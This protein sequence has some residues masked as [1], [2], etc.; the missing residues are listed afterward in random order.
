M[1]RSAVTAFSLVLFGCG[2]H[3]AKYKFDDV[4]LASVPMTEKQS[5][6]A[7]EQ[8]VSVAKAKRQAAEADV[9][10]TEHDIDLARVER[11]QARLSTQTAK[12]EMDAAEKAHDMNRQGPASD[13]KR[14]ADL[15]ERVA[16]AKVDMLDQKRK[17]QN[18]LI[19]VGDAQIDAALSRVEYEK[20][21]LAAAKNIRPTKDFNPEVFTQDFE[22]RKREVDEEQREADEKKEKLERLTQSWKDLDAQYQQARTVPGIAA[23]TK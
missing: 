9:R 1:K 7:A 19:E 18:E 5:I 8:E 6:F 3:A 13:K 2:G 4:A 16:N 14:I 21:K 10:T 12:L 11:E 15:G 22:K 20:A 23:P 17:W